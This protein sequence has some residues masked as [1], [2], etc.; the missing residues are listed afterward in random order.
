MQ[1]DFETISEEMR[2]KLM[3]AT[4]L[5]R[6]IAWVT[7]QDKNGLVNAAPFS[8]FNVF[9]TDPA[10]VGIGVGRNGPKSPKDTCMNIRVT[11]EFVV[12][13]VPF[14]ETEKMRNSSMPFPPSVSEVSVVGLQTR[15]SDRV[16]PP[17]LVESPV[18]FECKM[19]QEIRLGNFSLILGR[20][21][22]LHVR[23][24]AVLDKDR[25]RLDAAN[26]DLVGRMEGTLYT[27][28]HDKFEP[29]NLDYAQALL[30]LHSSHAK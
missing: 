26:M 27:R 24:E 10:T 15:A 9:G 22:M 8:F 7:T 5:P 14:S 25:P 21:L 3:L 2:Y 23:D 18:S 4:V 29:P 1:F 11:E 30:K 28:T 13:L 20:I 17:R 12:N 6:P 19:M 16:A